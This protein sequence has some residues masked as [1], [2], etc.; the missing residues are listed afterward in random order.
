MVE[1]RRRFRSLL[2]VSIFL[3]SIASFGTETT[4]AAEG[5]V[6][7]EPW[8]FV[9]SNSD[10]SATKLATAGNDL[11]ISSFIEN[12]RTIRTKSVSYTHLTLPTTPYV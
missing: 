3:L 6:P 9:D 12:E 11:I 7:L 4:Q 8:T 1:A 10:I 5:N 2:L